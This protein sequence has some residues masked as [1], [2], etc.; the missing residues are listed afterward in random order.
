MKSTNKKHTQFVFVFLFG[1][2]NGIYWAQLHYRKYLLKEPV[3]EEELMKIRGPGEMERSNIS[4]TSPGPKCTDEQRINIKRQ[5]MIPDDVST[6]NFVRSGWLQCTVPVWL[7][8]FYEEEA[9]IGSNRFLGISVGCNK[10][11]DAI[12]TARMGFS[13]TEFDTSKWVDALNIQA[14]GVCKQEFSGQSNVVYPRRGGEMHCIEPM[15]STFSELKRTSDELGLEHKGLVLTQ[16][17]IASAQGK[18]QFP[19]AKQVAGGIGTE[20]I[21]IDFC[22]ANHT[23]CEDV[24]VYSLQGYVDKYVKENGPINILQI[25]TEGWDFDVLFGAG[26]ILDRTHYLEFEYHSV[27]NWEN[28]HMPDA[29]RL[30]DGKGF[31]CY[32]AGERRLWRITQC[33]FDFYNHWHGWSNIACVHRSQQNLWDRMEN[34]FH[35]TLEM[36]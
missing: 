15:P 20:G 22:K 34:L 19:T 9:D 29:V 24:P 18:V 8:S 30:L 32:W 27:G 11:H 36:W 31:T 26:S 16:A 21:G 35:K 28:F 14:R 3:Y 13:S 25:D 6:A 4:S 2:A 17:A 33:Y 7:E 5:L 12:R 23:A 1:L 10:G